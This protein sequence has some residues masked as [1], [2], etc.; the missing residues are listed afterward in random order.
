MAEDTLAA[1]DRQRIANFYNGRETLTKEEA[2]KQNVTNVVNHLFGYHGLNSMRHQIASI[3]TR[4]NKVWNCTVIGEAVRP[5]LRDAYG[6][7]LTNE[8]NRQLRRSRRLRPEMMSMAGD[9]VLHGRAVLMYRDRFDWC[10]RNTFLYVPR[11]TGTTADGI[12]FAYSAE[13]L[14]YWQLKKYLAIAESAP[15]NWNVSALREAVQF[16]ESMSG[17]EVGGARTD[18]VIGERTD[19]AIKPQDQF[20]TVSADTK[21]TIPVWYVYE[22]DQDKADLPVSMKIV[23]RYSEIATKAD[24][25]VK[26]PIDVLLFSQRD[27]M[28]SVNQWIFPFFMD[29]EIGGSPSWHGATGIG[30]LNY[31]RDADVEEFFNLAMDGSKEAVRQKWKVMD[32]AARDKL[33]RFF[34]QNQDI[35]PEGVEPVQ[36]GNNPNYQHAFSIVNTLR[37]LSKEEA[38][39]SYSN[40]DTQAKELQIQA[41]ERQSKA[42]QMVGARMEEV[43]EGMDDVGREIFRRFL[44]ATTD[45]KF[46]GYRDVMIVRKRLAGLGVPYKQ[47]A[48]MDFGEFKHIQVKTSRATGEGSSIQQSYT[49]NK[50]MGWLGFFSAEGQEKIKR[51]VLLQETNDPDFAEEIVPIV[52]K[53]NPDQ[54]ARARN[55]NAAAMSRGITGFVPQINHDDIDMVHMPE[56]DNELDAVVAKGTQAGY[57]D[58]VDGAGFK[59]LATHQMAHVNKMEGDKANAERANLWKRKVEKQARQAEGLIA[60]GKQREEQMKELPLDERMKLQLKEQDLKHKQRVQDALELERDR[61]F[62]LDSQSE[63]VKQATS[64]SDT[65]RKGAEFAEKT[66]EPPPIEQ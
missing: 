30:K 4:N 34:A 32:G 7:H 16:L 65:A 36:I 23:A 50:L 21:M 11:G 5:D 25:E 40:S 17:E 61:R 39:D 27:H 47:L 24:S 44:V 20:S 2:E 41:A 64:I 53:P 3:Y 52:E 43:Y 37:Q 10:P 6:A 8:I 46:P 15:T 55:E 28:K 60:A 18:D 54:V 62:K 66:I 33:V 14:Q 57:L 51:R 29:A 13:D 45:T 35:I 42:N 48:D 19:S 38:A 49:N 59:S 31:E 12:S 1:T 22:V 9:L 56:H 63:A 58:Q 26:M